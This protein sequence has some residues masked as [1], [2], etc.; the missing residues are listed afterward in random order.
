MRT[1]LLRKARAKALER[2]QNEIDPYSSVHFISKSSRNIFRR[3]T[4]E[5]AQKIMMNGL[6]CTYIHRHEFKEEKTQTL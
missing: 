5:E 6:L 3:Y 2:F 1:K 4:I